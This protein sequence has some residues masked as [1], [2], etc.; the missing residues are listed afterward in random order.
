M[1]LLSEN[2]DKAWSTLNEDG[3]V[4]ITSTG[5]ISAGTISDEVEK[6][7]KAT[8]KEFAVLPISKNTIVIEF[9]GFFE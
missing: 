3:K 8:G 5:N 2:V 1:K 6:K 7:V 9:I 4:Y